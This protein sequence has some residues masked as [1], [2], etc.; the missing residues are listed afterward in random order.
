MSFRSDSFQ[1]GYNTTMYDVCRML[2]DD[3]YMRQERLTQVGFM[4]CGEH[5]PTLHLHALL[6]HTGASLLH[7]VLVC[8]LNVVRDPLLRQDIAVGSIGS[9]HGAVEGRRGAEKGVDRF[10]RAVG[11]LGID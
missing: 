3:N 4:I 11:G 5:K 6:G 9:L 8:L 1:I 7:K 10:E 2:P